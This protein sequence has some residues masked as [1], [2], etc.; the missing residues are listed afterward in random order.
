MAAHFARPRSFNALASHLRE[1]RHAGDPVFFIG[2]YDC[3]VAFYAQLRNSVTVVDPRS[4]AELTRDSWERERVDAAPFVP[5]TS[6]T[7]LHRSG[8]VAPWR[9]TLAAELGL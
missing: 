1:L 7:R 4:A 2:N 3:D 6:A 9:V 8:E 5:A